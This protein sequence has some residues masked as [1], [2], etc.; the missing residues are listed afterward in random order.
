M[1]AAFDLSSN[2][3]REFL[4]KERAIRDATIRM[5]EVTVIA[6]SWRTRV[7]WPNMIHEVKSMR[8]SNR[9]GSV[10]L[11]FIDNISLIF[12]DGIQP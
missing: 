10:S 1:P 9:W 7:L 8:R 2:D 6:Q 4:V 5:K 12:I 3:R 11:I